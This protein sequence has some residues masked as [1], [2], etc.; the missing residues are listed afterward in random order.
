[1]P[2]NS[3]N[4]ASQQQP[5]PPEGESR[6]L[7]LPD[8]QVIPGVCGGKPLISGHRITVRDVAILHED[9]GISPDEIIAQYP[10]LSLAQVHAALAYYYDHTDEIRQDIEEGDQLAAKMQRNTHSLIE[11]KLGAGDSGETSLPSG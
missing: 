4:S 9:L 6:N 3:S 7:P 2:P 8:I 5:S 10:G 11:K 1:M